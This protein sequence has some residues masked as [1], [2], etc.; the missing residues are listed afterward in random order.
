M[1]YRQF[2]SLLCGLL[3][4]SSAA[5]PLDI[6]SENAL[7]KRA[8]CNADNLL[9]L[10]RTP[11]NLPEALPFCK[12]YMGRADVTQDVFVATVTP[13]VTI[14]TTS[15]VANIQVVDVTTTSTSTVSSTATVTR[16]LTISMY[17][18]PSDFKRR[19]VVK[20]P[21]SDQVLSNTF[22]PSR[23]SSACG[24]L[25]LP[26]CNTIMNRITSTADVVTEVSTVPLVVNQ[27]DTITHGATVTTTVVAATTTSTVRTTV[28][29][30]WKQRS[31]PVNKPNPKSPTSHDPEH[32]GGM[33][34]A[35]RPAQRTRSCLV[36]A[37]LR[38]TYA[39]PR[40]LPAT[41]ISIS[42]PAAARTVHVKATPS[43]TSVTPPIDL[44]QETRSIPKLSG[45]GPFPQTVQFEVLGAPHSLLSVS[46]PAESK[47]YTRRGTLLGATASGDLNNAVSTLTLLKPVRRAMLGIP[48]LYQNISSTTPLTCLV[49]TN[50]PN[51][52]FAVVELDGAVDWMVTQRTALLAWTG[53]SIQTTPIVNR[54]MSPAQWSN[55]RISGRGLAALVGKGQVYQVILGDGEQMILHPTH[56]LAY[57][58]GAERPKPYRLAQTTLRFQL[59]KIGLV[60]G[61]LPRSAFLEAMA[62]TET[63]QTVSRAL[64]NIKTWLRRVI[65]GDRLFLQFTGPGTILIQ[66]RAARL[67]DMFTRDE[68]SD[69]AV[70]APGALRSFHPVEEVAVGMEDAGTI[71]S[72]EEQ[73]TVKKA[74]VGRNGKVT[75]EDSSA[76]EFIPSR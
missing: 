12:T 62:K 5:L 60:Q 14:T 65:W 47:L 53:H 36:N 3:I 4:G 45:K 44:S 42:T 28:T 29:I 31:S 9:R 48:F 71:A 34:F 41:P 7:G 72:R 22:P 10:L 64:F 55:T 58:I 69:M 76:D 39:L 68:I 32:Y 51:T 49:S 21:L 23:I 27:L 74:V 63:Y 70:A 30:D 40:L 16:T 19:D 43:T 52:T 75:F 67:Q 6:P 18:L 1:L 35:V 59:P 33:A 50:A 15:T 61:L 56:L 8:V 24:C 25:T 73:L 17:I 66:S 46:L 57:S 26:P 38:D 54:R 11:A 13:T 2:Q 20:T 37:F